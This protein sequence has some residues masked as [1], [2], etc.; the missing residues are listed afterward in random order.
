MIV[1]HLADVLGVKLAA[2]PWDGAERLP[3]MLAESYD[4][5][6]VTLDGA[7]CIFAEPLDQLPPVQTVLRHIELIRG[8]EALPV[9]LKLGDLSGELIRS[10]I[11]AR[12]PF[13]GPEQIYLPFL[14]VAL[15]EGLYAAPKS[16]KKLTP[17]AQLML[18]A[19]LY[20][21]SDKMST[22][23]LDERFGVSDSQVTSAVNQ[24]Q[25]LSLIDGVVAVSEDSVQLMMRGKTNHRELFESAVPYLLDPVREIAYAPIDGRTGSLPLAGLSA[26]SQWSMLSPPRVA[27]LAQYGKTD[28]NKTEKNR[29]DKTQTDKNSP[30]EISGENSS[31]DSD[32]QVLLELWKYDPTVLSD[33]PDVADPLSVI[34]SLKDEKDERV[35]KAIEEVLR[36]LWGGGK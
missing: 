28:K 21:K 18:L 13:T 9:A 24:L 7:V 31:I 5:R 1:L 8:V 22:R 4:F 14:G 35:T 10:L 30:D 12:I 6:K 17:T 25:K 2:K 34:A 36:T 20:Q 3:H 11:E 26:L 29:T 27:T 15:S 23:G 19:Y 32:Q 33:R 16:G